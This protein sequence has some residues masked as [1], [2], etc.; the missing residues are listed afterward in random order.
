MKK[1]EENSLKNGKIRKK[2]AKILLPMD[3]VP[4]PASSFD[5]LHLSFFVD[6]CFFASLKA[7]AAFINFGT[8]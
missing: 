8:T 1:V 4:H 3:K 2:S 5:V 6:V 7:S